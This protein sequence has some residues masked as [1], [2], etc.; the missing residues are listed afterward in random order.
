MAA[1]QRASTYGLNSGKGRR[2]IETEHMKRHGY[3]TRNPVIAWRNGYHAACD[4]IPTKRTGDDKREDYRDPDTRDYTRHCEGESI[5]NDTIVMP[6]S[7]KKKTVTSD[8]EAV[9]ERWQ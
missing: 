9:V 8:V 6:K 5:F 7:K 4:T 3:P 1:Q 2:Q